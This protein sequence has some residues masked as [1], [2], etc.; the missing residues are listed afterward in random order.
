MPEHFQML[1]SRISIPCPGT[2]VFIDLELIRL[3][4]AH[5]VVVLNGGLRA[6][7]TGQR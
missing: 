1:I 4:E 6:A 3:D 2:H 5:D 7:G